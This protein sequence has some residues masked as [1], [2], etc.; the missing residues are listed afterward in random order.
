LYNN[1]TLKIRSAKKA[2]KEEVLRFCIDTFDCGDYIDQ[3]W[4]LWR[5]DRNGVLLVAEQ[6]EYSVH[7]K[8]QSSV[9]AVSHASLCPDKK[10]IW[11]EGIRV[12]PHFRRRSVATQLINKM[13]SYGKKQEAKEASAMV[14]DNNIASQ[15]MMEKNGFAVI[16]K[17][18]YYSID[19]IPKRQDKV[20]TRSRI[21][22]LKDIERICNYLKQSQIFKS[23]GERY[24]NSW[25]W[26]SLD[27]YSSTLVDLIK[28]EKILVIGNDPIE[29]VA[30][31]DKDR[32]WNKN[33]N[34]TLQIVYLDAYNVFLLEDFIS[35]AINL[36]HSERA[37]YDR[38]QVYSPQITSVSKVMEQ[39]GTE[40]SDQFLLYKR[41]I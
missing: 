31:I 26:Y 18:S 1:I 17:W 32:F 27:L 24:V 9:I 13:I 37:I 14:A 16:S 41:E 39:L 4:D 11:L 6:E 29:G 33:N 22:T 38:I 35:F 5:L 28:N 15:L 21:A 20:T 36:I 23:S 40:R 3:V 8:K 12:N 19:K 34:T 7:D 30:V 2:D 25:R 10:N